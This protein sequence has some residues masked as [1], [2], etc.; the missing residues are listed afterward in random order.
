VRS[1]QHISQAGENL[2]QGVFDWDSSRSKTDR[3][4][5][6]ALMTADF[7][8]LCSMSAVAQGQPLRALYYGRRAVNTLCRARALLHGSKDKLKDPPDSSTPDAKETDLIDSMSSLTVSTLAPTP[9]PRA[10]Y[11]MPMRRRN[12]LLVPRL[13]HSLLRLSTLYTYGGL[14][15]EAYYYMEQ[16]QKVVKGMPSASY[17]ARF[18][19]QA[20]QLTNRSGDYESGTDHFD[21]AELAYQA[22]GLDDHYVE[23]QLFLAEKYMLGRDFGAADAAFARANNTL[24][25][26]TDIVTILGEAT[27]SE[28]MGLEVQMDRMSLTGIPHTTTRPD[29][30]ATSETNTSV[31]VKQP[32]KIPT[33][34]FPK[35]SSLLRFQQ[36]RISRQRALRFLYAGDFDKAQ[37][38]LSSSASDTVKPHQLVLQTLLEAQLCLRRGLESMAADLTFCVLPEST[39]SCPSVKPLARLPVEASSQ[40]VGKNDRS[41][42]TKRVTSKKPAR[43]TKAQCQP[44]Y[45]D[46]IGFLQQTQDTLS[47][48]CPLAIRAAST[49]EMHTLVDVLSRSLIMS[50]SLGPSMLKS[51]NHP[52]TISFVTGIV[53]LFQSS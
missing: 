18:H 51:H 6:I 47:E 23:F 52:I 10:A 21:K 15:R 31:T 40:V 33:K 50:S 22:N 20:G 42:R 3:N 49:A 4:H 8:G 43:A 2:Q 39:I 17:Q 19:A 26:V 35:A 14:S 28:N 12:W 11:M 46:F 27:N 24:D 9:N 38:L 44:S 32:I 53:R 41:G 37:E 7:A 25:R 36:A 34:V 30:R 13:F 29:Q 16:A 1:R 5:Q 48:V 45:P